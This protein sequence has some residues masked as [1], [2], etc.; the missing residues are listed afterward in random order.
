MDLLSAIDSRVSVARL[1]EPAPTPEDVTLML[2]A[3]VRAPDHGH[4]APW[5]F[6]VLTPRGRGLLA[7]A[8]AQARLR[9]NPEATAEQLE[10]ERAKVLRPPLIIVA[11]CVADAANVK[12]PEI[13]QIL[14]VGAAVQNLLL[15]AHAL[16]YGAIWKTGPAAYDPAVKAVLGLTPQDH[17]VS[18]VHLGSIGAMPPARA[19]VLQGVVRTF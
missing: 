13:E 12:I 15:A 3:A 16:G 11:A 4:L 18:F 10:A 9:R 7:G 1:I 14:A 2:T 5:R 19:A 8:A 17:I 6:I